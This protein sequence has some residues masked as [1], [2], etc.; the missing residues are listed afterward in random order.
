MD[1]KT[2]DVNDFNIVTTDNGVFVNGLYVAP[3]FSEVDLDDIAWMLSKAQ[4]IIRIVEENSRYNIKYVYSKELPAAGSKLRVTLNRTAKNLTEAKEMADMELALSGDYTVVSEYKEHS[5][6]DENNELQ[7][8]TEKVQKISDINCS[9][10][11][12][13][14]YSLMDGMLFHPNDCGVEDGTHEFDFDKQEYTYHTRVCFDNS[15]TGYSRLFLKDIKDYENKF[16]N[17]D[18]YN[19]VYIIESHGDKHLAFMENDGY[20]ATGDFSSGYITRSNDSLPFVIPM[21][22]RDEELSNNVRF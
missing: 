16:V 1:D 18:K 11:G 14:T 22:I 6:Y 2:F 21:I 12:V 3:N 7:S 19:T 4:E 13:L 10:E 9:E 15:E 5:L 17:F 20:S 8:L